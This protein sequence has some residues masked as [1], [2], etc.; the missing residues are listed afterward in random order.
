MS[1]HS[2]TVWGKPYDV[3]VDQLSKTVWRAVG[4]YEGQR[5]ETKGRTESAALKQWQEAARYRGNL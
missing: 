3:R 2:V 1:Q 4:N 5:I